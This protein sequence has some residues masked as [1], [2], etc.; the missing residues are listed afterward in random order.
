[1]F[2]GPFRS[3]RSASGSSTSGGSSSTSGGST[4]QQQQQQQQQPRPP[5][6]M[7]REPGPE[8]CCQRGCRVCVWDGA[9]WSVLRWLASGAR[10]AC[11]DVATQ[12]AHPCDRARHTR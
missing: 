6:P 8:D 1:M 11:P 9:C 7:P 5:P 4:Q 10:A 3:S 12:H 2:G